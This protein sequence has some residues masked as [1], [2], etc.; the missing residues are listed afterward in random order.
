[1]NIHKKACYLI[2]LGLLLGSTSILAAE[3]SAKEIM[4]NAYA[5]IGGMDQ[6]AFDAVVI[7]NDTIDGQVESHKQNIAVKI[8]RPANLRV[9]TKGDIKNRSITMHNGLFT[10][11]DIGFDYY[12]QL[13]TPNN[14]DETLDFLFDKYGIKAPLSTLMYSDMDKR[15]KFNNGK[16]FG[17]RDVSGI[18]C[19][20][21]AF[22]VNQKV[23]HIWVKTGDK[24]LIKTYSIVD[25]DDRIDTTLTWNT[26]PK[27]S[28]NDFVFTAP[29][30]ATKISISS[31]N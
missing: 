11:H 1:M 29:K 2:G 24:P 5:Y 17:I 19:D 21:V 28:E 25:G 12:G 27:I 18:E 22:R 15:L 9:D 14:I 26:N 31:A 13:E 23:I 4:T 20:Y 3:K 7:D 30:G 6:Y 8:D 10:I 16:Y